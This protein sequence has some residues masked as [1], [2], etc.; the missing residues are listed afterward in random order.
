MMMK[1][2]VTRAL[3]RDLRILRDLCRVLVY[4]HEQGGWDVARLG[5][6]CVQY[7]L[8]V[9]MCVLAWSKEEIVGIRETALILS[10]KHG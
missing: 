9:S 5:L 1:Q 10:A 3:I 2:L 8:V 4:S 7:L 6:Q